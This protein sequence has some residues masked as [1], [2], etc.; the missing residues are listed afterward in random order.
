[1]AADVGDRRAR[2]VELAEPQVRLG[3]VGERERG[4]EPVAS[5]CLKRQFRLGDGV[6]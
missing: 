4:E 5:T 2:V 1:M 6:G 3:L